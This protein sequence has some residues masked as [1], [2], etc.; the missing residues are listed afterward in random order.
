MKDFL[1]ELKLHWD[2]AYW[3]AD[4]QWMLLILLTGFASITGVLQKYCELKMEIKYKGK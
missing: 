1:D 3:W 4:R 2:D